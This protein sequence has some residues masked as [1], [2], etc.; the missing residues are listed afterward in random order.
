MEEPVLGTSVIKVRAASL[1]LLGRR[2]KQQKGISERGE[3]KQQFM[4][5]KEKRGKNI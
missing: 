5:L 3:K 2:K 4:Y 1:E